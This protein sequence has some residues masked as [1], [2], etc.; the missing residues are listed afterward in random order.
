M[1]HFGMPGVRASRDS[2]ETNLIWGGDDNKAAVLT[3][4]T[5]YDSTILD[6][7]ASPTTSIRAGLLVGESTATSQ[8]TEW[9]STATDGSQMLRGVVP[10]G[11]S[12]LDEDGTPEDQFLPMIIRAPLM[13]SNLLIQGAAFV[14]HADEFLARNILHGMGCI[15][16]DDPQGYLAGASWRQEIFT[17]TT[18]KTLTSADNYTRYLF[19][20]AAT[21]FVLP[22]VVA[23][24]KFRF[25][26]SEDFELSISSP[27]S[28]FVTGNDATGDGITW[29]T[30][31]EQIGLHVEVE[32]I[33]MD[34][35]GTNT[36]SWIATILKTA[37][38]TDDFLAHTIDT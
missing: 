21:N 2:V 9:V 30:D 25:F 17:G 38:S 3:M 8:M 32:A 27:T 24:L 10:L 4:G 11:F 16:D 28:V 37:F 33:N 23:G 5:Q 26:A 14:G 1:V 20:S 19:H 18:T 12:T 13:A 7:S 34:I 31:G 15:L 6:A 29:T 22:T 36:L 35:A